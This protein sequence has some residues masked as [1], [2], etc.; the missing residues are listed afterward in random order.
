MATG[1][2]R[3]GELGLYMKMLTSASTAWRGLGTL[4]V[5]F[6]LAEVGAEASST[7]LNTWCPA[8][9]GTTYRYSM[10]FQLMSS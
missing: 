1:N 2:S 10:N 8:Y 3:D 4:G 6:L 9:A 5:R 7:H